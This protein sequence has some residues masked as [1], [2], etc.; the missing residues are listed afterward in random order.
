MKSVERTAQFISTETVIS[1][2][3]YLLLL[4]RALEAAGENESKE[5]S[6][7]NHENIVA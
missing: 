6:K 3:E 4:C 7:T 5:M 1:F 2:A